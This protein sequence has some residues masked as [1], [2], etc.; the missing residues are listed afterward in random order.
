MFG[1]PLDADQTVGDLKALLG[2]G[3]PVYYYHREE[4]K[5]QES[6]DDMTIEGG[7]GYITLMIEPKTISIDGDAWE[8]DGVPPEMLAAP[9]FFDPTATLLME[10]RGNVID[11]NT[12]AAFNDLSVTVRHLSSNAVMTD[13]TDDDGQFSAVF[14]DIFSNQFYRIG[15]VFKIDI[16]SNSGDISFEPIQYTVTEEDVK[17]GR[18]ILSNLTAR[19]IPKHPKLMQ[20][21]PNPF[22]PETWIPFQLSKDADVTLTIY[23]IHGRLVRRFDL[24][25]VPAGIYKMKNN[26]I[27]WNGTNDSGERVSSGVYFYH[28]QAAGFSASRKMVILK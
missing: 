10:V 16:H 3:A 15:D 12:D 20:N 14:L 23:D 17:L 6:E 4:G 24:G 27:Y 11:A 13:T 19:A 22:N 7:A 28:I 5:F 21:W 26:A 8:N 2:E 18:I 1:V 25:Y 9:S